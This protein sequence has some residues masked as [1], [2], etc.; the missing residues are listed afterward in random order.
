MPSP[1]TPRYVKRT[2]QARKY[3]KNVGTPMSFAML[4]NRN[5]PAS[6]RKAMSNIMASPKPKRAPTKKKTTKRTLLKTISRKLF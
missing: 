3:K 2:A 5:T 1:S 6:L 4:M